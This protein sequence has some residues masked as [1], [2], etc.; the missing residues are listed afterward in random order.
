MFSKD[1]IVSLVGQ[2]L[3]CCCIDLITSLGKLHL[4]GQYIRLDLAQRLCK[5]HT[6]DLPPMAISD[7]RK[8]SSQACETYMEPCSMGGCSGEGAEQEAEGSSFTLFLL[9]SA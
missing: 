6:I 3:K 1:K 4:M 5:V 2:L 7:S 8:F 9:Q